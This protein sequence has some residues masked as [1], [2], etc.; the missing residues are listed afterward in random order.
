M[1]EQEKL[2]IEIIQK[3]LSETKADIRADLNELKTDI[4]EDMGEIKTDLKEI[5]KIMIPSGTFWKVSGALFILAIG[6]YGAY[7]V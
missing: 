1:T 7:I 6:S 5:R 4:R 2:L 3:D